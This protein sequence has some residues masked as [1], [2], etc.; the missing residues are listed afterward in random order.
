[1]ADP[2]LLT[3]G[4]GIV[5]NAIA[6]ALVERGRQVRALVRSVERARALVPPACQL[7]PA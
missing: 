1:M 3:G 6:H 2:V 4:T 5:G 7:V